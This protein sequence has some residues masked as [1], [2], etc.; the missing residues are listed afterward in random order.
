MKVNVVKNESTRRTKMDKR[1]THRQ[2]S[3]TEFVG[4]KTGGLLLAFSYT[5]LWPIKE[6]R[7]MYM[8]AEQ[9]QILGIMNASG[10]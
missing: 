10:R 6:Q 3:S 4:G 2:Q 8:H 5:A 9:V 1:K 7:G